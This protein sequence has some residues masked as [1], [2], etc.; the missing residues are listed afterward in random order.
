L[1][2][3]FHGINVEEKNGKTGF[4]SRRKK[5]EKI[6]KTNLER[7]FNYDGNTE[8]KTNRTSKIKN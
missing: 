6:T 2:D 5:N 3:T 4:I 7:L 8:S 1:F